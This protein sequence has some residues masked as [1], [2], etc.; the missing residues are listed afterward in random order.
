MNE[1]AEKKSTANR[2]VT[3]KVSPHRKTLLPSSKKIDILQ[4]RL[5]SAEVVL[6]EAKMQAI[7]I[8]GERAAAKQLLK[9]AK[10]Q[11]K[12]ARHTLA[13]AIPHLDLAS[14]WGR[15]HATAVNGYSR[16]E[17]LNGSNGHPEP[18][19]S[20]KYEKELKKLQA[21]LCYL[22]DWVK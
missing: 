18:L 4:K 7:R 10:K 14:A 3:H 21:E 22:Q 20:K 9:R 11:A 17:F 8:R 5:V 12:A 16:G 19:S 2:T 6:K 15:D 13:E 1:S